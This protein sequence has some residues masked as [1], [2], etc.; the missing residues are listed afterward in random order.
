MNKIIASAGM[1]AVGTT[2]L[3]ARNYDQI[4]QEQGGK[5]WSVSAAVRG[6]YD[7]NYTTRS[8]GPLKRDSIGF[9]VSPSASISVP[10]ETSYLGLSYIY[11]LSYYDDRDD[12]KTDQTHDVRLTFD[13]RFSERYH[14]NFLDQFVYSVE[15]T[16]L[17]QGGTI[18]V[19]LRADAESLHNRAVLSFDAQINPLWSV[20]VGYENNYYNY[21]DDEEPGSYSTLLDR[22]EHLFRVEPRYTVSPNTLAFV[23]Y[24]YGLNSYLSDELIS[25]GGTVKG[26]DR[27]NH[28]HYGYVGAE[29]K[30]TSVLSVEGRLGAQFVTYTELDEDQFSP[31]VDI[32]GTYK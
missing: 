32:V 20:L 30:F 5:R 19:P 8:S 10:M 12:N 13:H 3:L 23:G 15:P 2:G 16:L 18:T 14:A 25:P 29:H 11:T 27:D 24:Q 7:D 4:L 1:V 6:F 17:D 22:V 21:L 28:S 9:E 26:S 31:Y